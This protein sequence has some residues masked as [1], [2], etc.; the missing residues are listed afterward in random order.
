MKKTQIKSS[1]NTTEVPTVPEVSKK[2]ENEDK[3]IREREIIKK[4]ESRRKTRK[5]KS[6]NRRRK[7]RSK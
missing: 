3:K 5:E 1:Q 6:R 2:V 4:Q 7:R